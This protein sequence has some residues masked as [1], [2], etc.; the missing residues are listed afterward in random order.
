MADHDIAYLSAVDVL[1][2][3]HA[4]TMSPVD[5][6]EALIERIELLEPTINA[7]AERRYDEARQ[8]AM[9]AAARYLAGTA[10]PLEG[11]PVAAKEEH[12]MV[13]RSW[14]QGSL[15][16]A[17][18]VAPYD[19]PIIERIQAAGGIIHIRTTTPEFCCAGF[20]HSRQWGITRNPWNTDFSPGGSSGGSGAALAAGYAPLA[21]GSD[22]GGSIR[23]P[24]S[25]SG[26]VGF[27]PPW[28]RVPALAPYNLDQYCHDG[29]MARTVADCALLEDVIAGAH[30]RD[31]AALPYPPQVDCAG[32]SVEGLRIALCLRLGDWPL[33]PD[34]ERNTRRVADSLRA[35]GATVDEVTL[36]WSTADIW[37]TAQA[38]FATIMGAGILAVD[39]AHGE[40][41]S[42]YTRAF[43][44][45]FTHDLEFGFYEGLE[46][47]GAIWEPLGVLFQTYDALVCPTMA[48]SGYEAGNPYLA[49]GLVIGDG[50]VNHHILGAMTLPF[51]ILSRCPVVATPSGRAFNGVPTGVQVVGHPYDD[52]T[53][54]RVVAAV[55][56]TG[57]GF[58]HEHW[59][60][61]L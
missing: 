34:V 14:T 43:A 54:F 23:I 7:V 50:H 9:A 33:D 16:L 52:V 26:V 55:E 1:A 58:P 24:S 28:G 56:A 18:E 13:G 25:L 27:K 11:L 46:H 30:W 47:E 17:D 60:P 53:A 36:P 2:S 32:V 29:P 6:L 49:G 48:T 57:V 40:L 31:P 21:T 61:A 19:H 35:A 39:E 44:H 38:H 22:I 12:P 37:A 4:G 5:Y 20:C 8:E 59:R 15:S 41:L 51:N 3:F 42:D 45:D 10:R